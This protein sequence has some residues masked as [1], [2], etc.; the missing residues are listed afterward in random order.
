MSS[1]G[2]DVAVT[3][4]DDESSS[5]E[6]SVELG[7]EQPCTLKGSTDALKLCDEYF[8]NQTYFLSGRC[9]WAFY[10]CNFLVEDV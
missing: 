6:V 4:S 5:A 1:A 9:K 7:N 3:S 10:I 2:I 8:L